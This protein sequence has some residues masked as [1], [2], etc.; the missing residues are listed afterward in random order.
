MVEEL[1]NK[2]E[3]V[4]EEKKEGT[5]DITHQQKNIQ[6]FRNTKQK[7]RQTR[8]QEAFLADPLKH[9]EKLKPKVTEDPTDDIDDIIKE[10]EEKKK[11]KTARE[12]KVLKLPSKKTREKFYTEAQHKKEQ[13]YPKFQKY[14]IK[15]EMQEVPKRYQSNNNECSSSESKY[16]PNIFAYGFQPASLPSLAPSNIDKHYSPVLYKQKQ[17]L[18]QLYQ[19][20]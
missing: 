14:Q 10:L 19:R 12:P 5:L 6:E 20:K 16:R 7:F 2:K 15:S 9:F 1:Q 11:K 13:H 4:F 8:R 3:V 18:E 17:V